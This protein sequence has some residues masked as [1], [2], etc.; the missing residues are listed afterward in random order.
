[1]CLLE[2]D[3]NAGTGNN[4]SQRNMQRLMRNILHDGIVRAGKGQNNSHSSI[5][6]AYAM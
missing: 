1:M 4:L 6:T 3:T 2:P 5:G